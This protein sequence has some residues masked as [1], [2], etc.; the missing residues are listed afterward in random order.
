MAAPNMFGAPGGAPVTLTLEQAKG[1]DRVVS[2]RTD[3]TQG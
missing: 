3:G 2:S 1:R